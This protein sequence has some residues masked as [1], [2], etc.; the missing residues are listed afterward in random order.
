MTAAA[1]MSYAAGA[2]DALM[3]EY[4]KT[5]TFGIST[6]ER[7][8]SLKECYTL[9]FEKIPASADGSHM[10]MSFAIPE[11][12]LSFRTEPAQTQA[13]VTK[14]II[15]LMRALC[16]LMKTCDSV[17]EERYL[18]MS[19]TY[20]EHTPQDYEPPGFRSCTLDSPPKL[21]N[22]PL[23]A[24]A[25]TQPST[26]IPQSPEDITP[27]SSQQPDGRTPKRCR[28]PSLTA[29]QEWGGSKCVAFEGWTRGTGNALGDTECADK[30]NNSDPV[31]RPA[32]ARRK[33]LLEETKEVLQKTSPL[34][35]FDPQSLHSTAD[36]PAESE[37]VNLSSE[38]STRSKPVLRCWRPTRKRGPPCSG[39]SAVEGLRT[40]SQLSSHPSP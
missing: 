3:K 31:D 18:T 17:P 23:P 33:V 40:V 6:N 9:R 27:R 26:L 2:S 16:D 37:I 12:G 8:S 34:S 25:K 19:L 32:A 14:M 39:G 38:H 4:L 13:E 11:S 21:Y 30:W 15:K 24:K 29:H 22:K 35:K 28:R 7:L 10:C 36:T 5:L 20:H 1:I